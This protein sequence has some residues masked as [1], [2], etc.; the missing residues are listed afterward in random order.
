MIEPM[1]ATPKA[2][3]TWRTT[4]FIAE[5]TP[6]FASGTAP[7]TASVAGAITLPIPSARKKIG[8]ADHPLGRLDVPEAEAGQDD[9]DDQ[10]PGGDDLGRAEPLDQMVAA[11]GADHDAERERDQPDAGFERRCSRGRT[12]GTG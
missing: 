7:I 6:A 12:A 2:P 5:P 3:A 4:S 1:I 8:D 9:G 11:T 10:H